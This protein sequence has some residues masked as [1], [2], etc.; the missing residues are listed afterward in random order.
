MALAADAPAEGAGVRL[1]VA[2]LRDDHADLWR[3]TPAGLP[4]LGP[5][6][7][8][9]RHFAN[10][11]AARRLLDRLASETEKLPEDEGGRRA[12]RDSVAERLREFGAQRLGWLRHCQKDATGHMG[13]DMRTPLAHRA[14]PRPRWSVGSLHRWRPPCFF[15]TSDS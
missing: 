14:R 2:A 11:R 13:A 7:G 8:W 10:E 1:D 12:W 3:T 5:R 6:V 4:C 15:T 9:R